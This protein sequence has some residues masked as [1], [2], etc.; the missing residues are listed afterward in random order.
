MPLFR[1]GGLTQGS[2]HFRV[3]DIETDLA[4]HAHDEE[5]EQV[6]H[7]HVICCWKGEVVKRTGGERKRD[8]RLEAKGLEVGGEESTGPAIFW[9]GR[10][11][12][13]W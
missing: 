8:W 11:P 4:S 2:V 1:G 5:K 10:R 3:A 12:S 13:S 7:V 6:E 9:A